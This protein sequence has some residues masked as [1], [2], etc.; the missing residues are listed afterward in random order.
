MSRP[1]GRVKYV[2]EKCRCDVCRAAARAYEKSRV[3]R[4][5]PA[6]VAATVAREH[7]RE[8]MAAGVGLKQIVK[9]SGVSTGALWK[10]LYGKN[11]RPSKRIRRSTEQALL[12]VTPADIADGARVAAGPTWVLID[13]MVAAGVPRARI[14]EAIGQQGPGLQLS[15]STVT[16]RNARAVVE[17]HARWMA[18]E[19][20]LHRD[21]RYTGPVPV[22]PPPPPAERGA[23][24]VSEL[25][26]ELAEIVEERREQAEWRQNAACRG[27]GTWMWFPGR[28]DRVT[29]DH[30]LRICRACI[31]R[32]QCRAANID[33]REGVY[34]A[35]SAIERRRLRSIEVTAA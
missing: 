31:V 22:T 20:V 29:L 8:L 12:S 27:R 13:E 28:G 17:V 5:E 33:R 11:G 15:R 9:S 35:M 6:Y 4:V 7:C 32:D 14:A 24:D 3:S 2:R 18:G 21:H 26:V 30:A 10:L 25:L 23:A 19:L 1:H 34:G 16:A